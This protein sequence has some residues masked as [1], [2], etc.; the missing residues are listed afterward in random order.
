MISIT[1]KKNG[2][3][4]AIA[5]IST[6]LGWVLITVI[7]IGTIDWFVLSV[8]NLYNRILISMIDSG[9]SPV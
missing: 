6:V 1:V 2:A 7:G 4:M 9:N 8:H 5:V 3:R